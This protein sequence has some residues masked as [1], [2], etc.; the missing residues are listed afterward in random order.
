MGLHVFMT[1]ALKYQTLG[2]ILVQLGIFLLFT[3]VGWILWR[4]ASRRRR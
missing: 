4:M 1:P 2:Y 3:E